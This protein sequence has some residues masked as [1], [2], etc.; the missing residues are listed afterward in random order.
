MKKQARKVVL[1]SKKW[2]RLKKS[3]RAAYQELATLLNQLTII[4]TDHFFR[5]GTSKERAKLVEIL[6]SEMSNYYQDVDDG[7]G[8]SDCG[9]FCPDGTGGCKQ[10]DSSGFVTQ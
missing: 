4:A 5:A 2:R 3:D 8:N 10:C 6:R 7:S 1:K 9:P